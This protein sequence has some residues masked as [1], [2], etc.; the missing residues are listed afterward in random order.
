MC[1][2]R[3][4]KSRPAPKPITVGAERHHPYPLSMGTSFLILGESNPTVQEG[5][6]MTRVSLPHIFFSSLYRCAMCEYPVA[7]RPKRLF[8]SGGCCEE[9]THNLFY[10]NTRGEEANTWSL[11]A[12]A[13]SNQEPE[14]DGAEKRCIGIFSRVTESRQQADIRDS[15]RL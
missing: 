8:Q 4:T 14:R 15:A 12:N 2:G 13:W 9:R 6:K 10:L 3:A 11:I 7:P 1:P 5:K